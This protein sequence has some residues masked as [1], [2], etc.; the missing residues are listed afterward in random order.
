MMSPKHLYI[1]GGEATRS[2]IQLPT[3]VKII[4]SITG[5]LGGI[6]LWRD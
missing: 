5:L 1:G 6:A 3:N 4:P 2:K